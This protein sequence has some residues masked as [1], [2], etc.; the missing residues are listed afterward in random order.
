[1]LRFKPC[2]EFCGGDGFFD[3]QFKLAFGEADHNLQ[4][5]IV[6]DVSAFGIVS[7]STEIG[8]RE[9]FTDFFN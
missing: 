7:Q 1:M 5:R 8:S 3:W 2:P 6:C 9:C 4:A